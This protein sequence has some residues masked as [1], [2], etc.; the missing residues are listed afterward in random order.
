MDI[1]KL[2]EKITELNECNFPRVYMVNTVHW[3][4]S[5]GKFIFIGDSYLTHSTD[6][7]ENE[8]VSMELCTKVCTATG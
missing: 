7:P 3:K 8:V 1:Q 6:V 4:G 5:F 2:I